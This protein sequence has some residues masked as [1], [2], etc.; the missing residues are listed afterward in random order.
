[1]G[2]RSKLQNA[3]SVQKEKGSKQI[4]IKSHYGIEETA[5]LIKPKDNDGG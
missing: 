3:I 5:K 4:T 1:L 2:W